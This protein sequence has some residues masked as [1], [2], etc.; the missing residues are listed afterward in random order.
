MC[1]AQQSPARK[2]VSGVN[3]NV[4]SND[5]NTTMNHN[6]ASAENSHRLSTNIVSPP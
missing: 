5:A 1:E 6:G 2:L 3:E 4:S